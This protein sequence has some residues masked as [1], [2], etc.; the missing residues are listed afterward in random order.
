MSP[1]KEIII[2]FIRRCDVAARGGDADPYVLLD[3]QV[4]FIVNGTTPLS[5]TFPG[6]TIIKL[7]LVNTVKK[8]VKRGTVSVEE[9][10]GTGN[11]V[12]TLLMIT[13][14][15]LD[16]KVYNES[17]E[18][19]GCLFEVKDGKISEIFLFPDTTLIE[20]VIYNRKYVLNRRS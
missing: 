3:K 10:V 15:T 11:R 6:L 17:S 8:R 1:S 20:T 2:E 5:G 18:T 14:E 4:T 12:A 7:V 13:A 9:F 19:C 16:G